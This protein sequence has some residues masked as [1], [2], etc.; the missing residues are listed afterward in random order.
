MTEAPFPMAEAPWLMT[1]APPR[2]GGP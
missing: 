2:A 1:E